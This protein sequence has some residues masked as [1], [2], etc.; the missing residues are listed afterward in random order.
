MQ[1]YI[2]LDCWLYLVLDYGYLLL[3]PLPTAV[4]GLLD[5]GWLLFYALVLPP[6]TY[7]L[8]SALPLFCTLA[9]W[10]R[11]GLLW[12]CP[13]YGLLP[14]VPLLPCVFT[15]PC[16]WLYITGCTT[17]LP[18]GLRYFRLVTFSHAGLVC[19]I[20]TLVPAF[21]LCSLLNIHTVVL[22]LTLLLRLIADF[23]RPG[24]CLPCPPAHRYRLFR[25]L[26]LL[27]LCQLRRLVALHC[28]YCGSSG[29]PVRGCALLRVRYLFISLFFFAVLTVGCVAFLR[30]FD[31]VVGYG[32]YPLYR[33]TAPILLPSC[34]YAFYQY[35]YPHFCCAFI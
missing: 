3:C 23:L 5:Y 31:S 27:V 22:R 33:A 1:D 32:C 8:G 15:L 29:L 28:A 14:A 11:V 35:V 25:M 21:T 12:F 13:L 2:V 26:L 4:A 30:F 10:L 24:F 19:Y 6:V 7:T 16:W 18:F 34:Y 9:V 20:A 17:L